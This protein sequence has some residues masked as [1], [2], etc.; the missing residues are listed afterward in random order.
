MA[1]FFTLLHFFL[2]HTEKKVLQ[3]KLRKASGSGKSVD[4]NKSASSRKDMSTSTEDLGNFALFL[5]VLFFLINPCL[6]KISYGINQQ[7]F[8][9]RTS[10]LKYKCL[11]SQPNLFLCCNK[12]LAW[13]ALQSYDFQF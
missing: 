1:I 7:V 5:L 6:Y 12:M 10:Q 11:I 9:Y 4:F 3:S 13:C 2:F 8:L